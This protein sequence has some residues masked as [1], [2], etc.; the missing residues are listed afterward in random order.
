LK[1]GEIPLFLFKIFNFLQNINENSTSINSII[2]DNIPSDK[3]LEIRDL[4]TLA[5]IKEF[6]QITRKINGISLHEILESIEKEYN[7]NN[8]IFK[9]VIE[10]IFDMPVFKAKIFGDRIFNSL[11]LELEKEE[12]IKNA[13]NNIL[14]LLDI[15]IEEYHR[16]FNF[17]SRKQDGMIEYHTYHGT[18][19]LQFTNE[20][21]IMENSFGKINNYFN[22]YFENLDKTE[23]L[24]DE[25]LTKFT[26]IKNLLY[27]ACSRAIYNL[28]I[29]Y[30]DDISSFKDN[31]EHVFGKIKK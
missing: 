12:D 8:E 3:Y 29:L 23:S 24:N 11:Y 28:D 7:Q 26:G 13:K 10:S 20:L 22:F 6:V 21:I 15:K 14:R 27:V 4:L 1:L 2:N 31:I 25:E 18:K 19:G 9:I 17:I 16:W 30:L 5:K